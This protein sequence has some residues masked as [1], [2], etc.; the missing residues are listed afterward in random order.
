MKRYLLT[1]LAVATAF[2]SCTKFVQDED[3]EFAGISSPEVKATT[4]GDTEISVTITPAEGTTYYSYVVSKGAARQLDAT[5]LL[6]CKYESIAITVDEKKVS[7]IALSSE[8]ASVSLSLKGLVPNTTYTV[9]AVARNSQGVVSEVA[10]ASALTTDS[11][12]PQYVARSFEESDSLLL[13]TVKFDD[14]VVATGKGEVTAKFYGVN[15]ALDA[16]GL[17]QVIK[18]VAVPAENVSS[19]ASGLLY[20]AVPKEYYIPGAFVG[21]DWTADVAENALGAKVPAVTSLIGVQN[22]QLATAGVVGQYENVPF[23][24]AL[25]EK[26]ED[27]GFGGAEDDGEK[28]GPAIFNDWE[29]LKMVS[30]ARTRHPLAGFVKGA[31]VTV[32]SK[33]ASG[34][35]VSYSGSKYGVAAENAVAVSLDEDPGFGSLVSYTIAAGSVEDIYG[36]SNNELVV[37]D[38]YFCSYGYKLDDIAGTY[39]FSSTSAYAAYGYGPYENLLTIAA[40]DN[41]KAGNVMFTGQLSDI[42]VK[43]YANFD[44]DAGTITL[45]EG[46]LVGTC[47]EVVFGENDEPL[48]GDDGQYVTEEYDV[49]LYISNGQSLYTD[50]LGFDV[51]VA[52]Q[53]DFWFA[54]QAYIALS[55]WQGANLAGVYDMLN[56]RSVTYT[57]DAGPA[58]AVAQPRSVRKPV[59]V[60][61]VLQAL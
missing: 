41:E 11:T 52:H 5:N 4:V 15:T 12:A 49:K 56:L 43:F 29:E 1:I 23:D 33:D 34:R 39:T 3:I 57:P 50:Q 32:K 47:V 24:L 8:T 53:L 27:G 17:F 30:Y 31:E 38:G 36:N 13:F 42:D 44:M 9:Y 21:I 51:P 19:D 18:S 35:T 61:G 58:A 48:V 59:K 2:A 26:D 7:G 28:D 37:E 60:E 46:P 6:Q 40:S 25:T 22:N 10:S 20:I 55:E 14:P 16:N 54:G 45:P